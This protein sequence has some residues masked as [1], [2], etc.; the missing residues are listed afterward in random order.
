MLFFIASASKQEARLAK[1]N[2]H[3]RLVSGRPLVVRLVEKRFDRRVGKTSRS[4]K[5]AAIKNTLKTMEEDGCTSKK[6]KCLPSVLHL[7][8][9]P[10][11]KT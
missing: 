4:A 8:I 11:K 5:I 2:M 7:R 3:G 10:V 9:L 6:Q 1:E